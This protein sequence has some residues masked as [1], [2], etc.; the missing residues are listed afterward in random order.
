MLTTLLWYCIEAILLLCSIF[1]WGQQTDTQ[2]IIIKIYSVGGRLNNILY[3]L[4]HAET[5]HK[6]GFTMCVLEI[7]HL[8]LY[9]ME[10]MAVK[11]CVCNL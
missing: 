8:L 1:A 11:F 4:G 3:Y 9:K 5:T 2:I 6:F 10:K 7:L